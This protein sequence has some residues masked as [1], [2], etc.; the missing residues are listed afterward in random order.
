[1]LVV[2]LRGRDWV[3]LA[4]E[5]APLPLRVKNKVSNLRYVDMPRRTPRAGSVDG[6]DPF[7]I[8]GCGGG[9]W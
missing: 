2:S 4:S 7:L 3:L 1:L 8:G 9:L 6:L 5:S